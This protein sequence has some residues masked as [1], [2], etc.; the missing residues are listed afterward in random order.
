M[1]FTINQILSPDEITEIKQVL[2]RAKFIN[3]K[4]TAGWHAK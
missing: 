3:G 2:E 1:I 4:L